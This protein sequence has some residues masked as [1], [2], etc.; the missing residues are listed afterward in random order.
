MAH[1][2]RPGIAPA[3][4]LS[5]PQLVDPN[6]HR[7]VVLL[8]EHNTDGAFGL[9]INRPTETSASQ[10]VRLLPPPSRD[11]GLALWSGGPV[12]PQRG[13]I[14]MGSEPAESEAVSVADGV[15]LS[16]SPLLLRR[17]IETAPPRT[18]VL[19]GY[20]GWGPGQLEGEI[21]AGA[22]LVLDSEPGD[23][24]SSEPDE[25]W[26]TVLRRQGG[27]LAW[28]ADAPDDLSSN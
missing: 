27:R 2:V 22:W 15:Y 17:L 1:A 13:W 11:G 10:A 3:L 19:T 25:L 8:C 26:R 20:A 28:L 6:F 16:T 9:V 7:T 23:I 18:R 12:E 4:L 5:M 21:E 24:F 14:L